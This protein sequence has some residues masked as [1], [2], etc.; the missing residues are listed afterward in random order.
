[1]PLFVTERCAPNE[2]SIGCEAMEKRGRKTGE[3]EG[4]KC[5]RTIRR[6]ERLKLLILRVYIHVGT[7]RRLG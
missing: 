2:G 7:Y 4:T 1:M 5:T 6:G 3:R